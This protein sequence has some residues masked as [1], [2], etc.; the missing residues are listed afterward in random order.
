MNVEAPLQA[1]QNL[2]NTDPQTPAIAAEHLSKTYRTGFWLD[3]VVTPLKD[4]SLVVPAGETFGLLGPNGA[5]KTTL[6]KL[7][8]GIVQPT[9]GTGKLLGKNIGDRQTKNKVGY[10]PENAYFYDYLSGWEYLDFIGKLFGIDRASRIERMA[11]LLDLV[12][13]PQSAARRKQIKQ[14]SKGM[15]QRLGMA[16]A[17]MN[18]P[19]L[20]FLDEPMS[21]LDPLGRYQ[22][23]EIILML[24]KRGKTVF[25][26]SHVLA[27][28][29]IICD[30]IGILNKGEL[31]CSGS[32]SELLGEAAY[33]QVRGHGGTPE[34]LEKWIDNLE[35]QGNSWHGQLKR[36]SPMLDNSG[37]A[38]PADL[39]KEPEK[40]TAQQPI[41]GNPDRFVAALSEMGATLS[42]LHLARQSL[43]EFFISQIRQQHLSSNAN[44]DNQSADRDFEPKHIDSEHPG[45]AIDAT[46]DQDAESKIGDR[47]S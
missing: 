19:E 41:A 8:L 5:G 9:S 12:G 32:L 14:Y 42:D 36:R 28:V 4:C 22:I 7:L 46:I 40:T 11:D 44:H 6:L 30:R 25:F 45:A 24:K 38:K 26:N 3:R 15:M 43:E 29:E 37:S 35:F 21:G 34:L 33:F 18:D 20:V 16:Q 23:R 17:L 13:L 27:D 10:L 31:I 39:K 1:N 2:D 47:D